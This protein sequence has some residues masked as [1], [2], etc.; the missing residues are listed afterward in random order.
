MGIKTITSAILLVVCSINYAQNTDIITSKL[1]TLNDTIQLSTEIDFTNPFSLLIS[2]NTNLKSSNAT[3]QI[4][5]ST[6]YYEWQ[7]SDWVSSSKYIYTY[8]SNANTTSETEYNWNESS[9]KWVAYSKNEYAYNSNNNQTQILNYSWD[10]SSAQW[11]AYEKTENTY[12]SQ[13]IGNNIRME[14]RYRRMG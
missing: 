12:D 14:Y 3:K 7:N 5:D 1:R 2:S 8:D 4:C 11:I 6:Y 13:N 10:S 9:E